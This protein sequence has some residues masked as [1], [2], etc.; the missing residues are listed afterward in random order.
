MALPSSATLERIIC[1]SSGSEIRAIYDII[2]YKRNPIIDALVRWQFDDIHS[3]LLMACKALRRAKLIDPPLYVDRSRRRSGHAHTQSYSYSTH[4]VA[5][6]TSLSTYKLQWPKLCMHK[7]NKSGNR[8]RAWP[9]Q[10]QTL[11]NCCALDGDMKEIWWMLLIR[12][13]IPWYLIVWVPWCKAI[14]GRVFAWTRH[15]TQ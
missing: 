14:V 9:H 15:I 2:N 8:M 10:L 12:N 7:C 5:K 13:G 3:A 4:P 6:T 1:I 11:V